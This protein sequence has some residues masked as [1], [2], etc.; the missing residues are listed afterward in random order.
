[1]PTDLVID[2]DN[3]GRIDNLCFV[4]RGAP[5]G[6]SD[7]LW[8]HQWVIQSNYQING[9]R[10]WNYNLNI[11]NDLSSSGVGTLAHEFGHTIGMPDLYRYSGNYEPIGRWDIMGS[12][13]NP[14]IG[15]SA[16][17]KA[18]YTDWVPD[19]PIISTTGTYSL[20]PVTV[21]MF[22]HAYRINSPFS[23]SEYF[24]VEYRKTGTGVIDSNIYGSGLL[25]YR[26]NTY[27]SNGN[28]NPPDELY[29]YR[30]NGTLT[31][32]GY[33][34][35]AYFNSSVGRT[36][37][38]DN[39][40]P[41][42]FLSDNS[43]GGL[44]VSNIGTAGNT[45]SF[46]VTMPTLATPTN[47]TANFNGTAV[48]LSWTSPGNYMT[49]QGYKLYRNN[50]P[51]VNSMLTLT[52]FSDEAIMPG[53]TYTYGVSA[54]YTDGESGT[55]TAQATT[56]QIVTVTNFPWSEN[57]ESQVFPSS[58]WGMIDLD[59]D[60]EEW[61]RFSNQ[62][63]AYNGNAFAASASRGAVALTPD[64]WLVTPCLQLPEN[65]MQLRFYVGSTNASRFEEQYSIMVST[66]GIQ[67]TDFVSVF[68][69]TLT[70][71]SWQQRIINL[72]QFAGQTIRIAFRHHNV[73]DRAILKLDYV[74]VE[75]AT[76]VNDPIDPLV[77]TKLWGNYPNPFN[78][79]TEII[80]S[81]LE[82][83]HVTLDIYNIKGQRVRTLVNEN[84]KA[85]KQVISWNGTDDNDQPVVS[86][87]YFYQMRVGEYS[88]TKRMMLLK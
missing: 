36:Q 12:D 54:V 21:D 24:I 22:E 87:V 13:M 81:L 30:P 85:G 23:G 68:N 14:P 28:M 29:V 70:T 27:T 40:N 71:S 80:F 11:E 9:K 55:V 41:R 1:V 26:V 60:A 43:N 62:I 79:S 66:T 50:A 19:I 37:I 74:F 31:N 44:N 86:G 73:T 48:N 82:D 49:F 83:S 3:D 42:S 17:M 6:W 52:N 64:N 34:A 69:E 15:L 38:N 2:A 88:S 78:P 4:L 63:S 59:H 84:I 56:G 46:T 33:I 47:L 57:F 77:V 58:G 61:W 10:A 5:A 67:T 8:P 16:Y 7:V 32:N 35:N 25:V 53:Q 39:T 45:I 65:S 18:R 76:A 75:S 72:S 51:L 20:Y